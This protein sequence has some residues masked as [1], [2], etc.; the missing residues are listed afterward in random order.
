MAD[1][2]DDVTQSIGDAK[3]RDN[4]AM[5]VDAGLTDDS[6]AP[7]SS[8]LNPDDEVTPTE[9]GSVKRRREEEL[10]GEGTLKTRRLGISSEEKRLDQLERKEMAVE[11]SNEVEVEEVDGATEVNEMKE[12]DEVKEADEEKEV[13]EVKEV[14]EVR[15]VEE[16]KEAEEV[17]EVSECETERSHAQI[18]PKNF[19]SSVQ[20]FDYFHKLL[21]YW[22]PNLDVNKYEHILLLELLKKGHGEAAKK[23]GAGVQSFQVRYHPTWKSRC[24]F[25]IRIDGSVDDFS[26]RKCVDHILPLPE[27]MKLSSS[28]N[29]KKAGGQQKG[30]GGFRGRGRGRG[31]RGRG[32]R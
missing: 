14:D 7:E 20:M 21:N 1:E 17:E 15:E 24:F 16:V 9:N 2:A 28:S 13:E 25:L 3:E 29:G 27:N 11:E 30:G 23:I 19:S 26:F 22:P 18:G 4:E 32:G 10:E 6:I 8:G 12:L 5:D 31:G